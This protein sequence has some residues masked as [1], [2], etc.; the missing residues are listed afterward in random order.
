MER[1]DFC[2]NVLKRDKGQGGVASNTRTSH[3]CP[4]RAFNRRLWLFIILLFASPPP[5]NQI[6]PLRASLSSH[7]ATQK[8][9]GQ[10]KNQ[11]HTCTKP[12]KP[13]SFCGFVNAC[14]QRTIR[15][16]PSMHPL[17]RGKLLLQTSHQRAAKPTKYFLSFPLSPRSARRGTP[18]KRWSEQKQQWELPSGLEWLLEDI[19]LDS[20]VMQPRCPS[21]FKCYLQ[22][23]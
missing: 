22:N 18:A 9:A 12:P 20:C 8:L 21:I 4:F 23:L 16:H 14:G 6:P 19:T 10:D 15:S 1:V 13:R 5:I 7:P 17:P 3:L 11:T 2:L